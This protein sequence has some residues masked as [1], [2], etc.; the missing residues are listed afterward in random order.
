[1]KIKSLLQRSHVF[2]FSLR[3]LCRSYKLKKI[4]RKIVVANRRSK[5]KAQDRKRINFIA[6][7]ISRNPNLSRKTQCSVEMRIC[8]RMK[9]S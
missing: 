1:M 5:P 9:S 4:R 3:L 2:N 8:W 7:V 6:N